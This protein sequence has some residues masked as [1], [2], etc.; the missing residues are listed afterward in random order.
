ML[1]LATFHFTLDSSKSIMMS[2]PIV[3]PDRRDAG[4]IEFGIPWSGF[5]WG[6]RNDI[7]ARKRK[8]DGGRSSGFPSHT[9]QGDTHLISTNRLYVN[10]STFQ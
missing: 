7:Q 6:F 2:I 4:K 1:L 3:N 5:K 9:L 10:Y 8:P